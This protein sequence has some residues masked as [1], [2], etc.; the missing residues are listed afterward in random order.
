MMTTSSNPNEGTESERKLTKKEL[1]QIF[2]RSCQLDV[3][4]NY[5][6][7]QNLG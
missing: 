1:R 7:Q 3:S 4:W 2:W 5:E 6:R